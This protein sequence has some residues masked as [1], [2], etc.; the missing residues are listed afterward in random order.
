MVAATAAVV[1]EAA[2]AAGISP[3][4]RRFQLGD[5][6]RQPLHSR[7]TKI[8]LYPRIIA[9][10]FGIDDHAKA[11]FRVGDALAD[12]EPGTTWTAAFRASRSRSKSRD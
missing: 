7:R 8:D 10:A 9:T 5:R 11:K 1:E 6:Q 3:T 2:A 4:L 12:A